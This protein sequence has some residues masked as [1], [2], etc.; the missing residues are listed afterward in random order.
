[1]TIY[2]DKYK[3]KPNTSDIIII[4]E[5]YIIR[6]PWALEVKILESWYKKINSRV[7]FWLNLI[8]FTITINW[9]WYLTF[10]EFLL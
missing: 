2:Y 5:S 10:K 7:V 8:A 1:M 6:I 3:I 9:H 4:I